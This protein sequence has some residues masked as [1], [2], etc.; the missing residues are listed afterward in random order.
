MDYLLLVDYGEQVIFWIMGFA[1]IIA[2][3]VFLERLVIYQRNMRKSD[4]IREDI[5]KM[6]RSRDLGSLSAYSSEKKKSIYA[7]FSEFAMEHYNIGLHGLSELMAGKMVEE[8]IYLERRLPILG[9]LGNNAPFIGL[10]GTVL[11]VIKAFNNLGTLGNQGAEIVMR[12]I[13]T[14][15]LATAAGL[16]IAIPVVMA[17]NYFSKKVKVMTQNLDILSKE[18]LANY[19]DKTQT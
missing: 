1:S 19:P 2:L 6:I 15:L 13:A 12:N 17:N 3:A 18:F 8:R 9:T 14:A 10:L 16:L 5:V 7:R 11:G 4:S